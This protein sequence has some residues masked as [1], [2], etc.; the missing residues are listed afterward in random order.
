[1]PVLPWSLI[2]HRGWTAGTSVAL[3]A[4]LFCK[5]MST[6]PSADHGLLSGLR[7]AL[8]GAQGEW[9]GLLGAPDLLLRRSL[10][11]SCSLSRLRKK[12]FACRHQAPHQHDV[13]S[14]KN[15]IRHILGRISNYPLSI[16]PSISAYKQLV[17]QNSLHL[18]LANLFG[19]LVNFHIF[20][21]FPS[22]KNTVSSLKICDLILLVS[23]AS[24]VFLGVTN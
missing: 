15:V 4:E 7:T 8:G 20:T 2:W 1:M 24:E 6:Q 10:R 18:K 13:L 9:W 12:C 21:K 17:M 5:A 11:C 19:E 22:Y 3:V 14:K 23:G 16:K